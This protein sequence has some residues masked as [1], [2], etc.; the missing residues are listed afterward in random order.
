MRR[1]GRFFPLKDYRFKK[2]GYPGEGGI[3]TLLTKPLF[4]S[5]LR[6]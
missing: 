6:W 1:H 5:L 3:G 4:R 2:K